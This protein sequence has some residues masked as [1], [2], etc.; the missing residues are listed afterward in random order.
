[1]AIKKVL[2]P[3]I[4][5]IVLAKRRGARYI[6]LS[7]TSRGIV[8][9]GM[10][11]WTPYSAGIS[12]AKARADWIAKHLSQHAASDFKDGDRFGKAHRLRISV[13][14]RIKAPRARIT[15][16]EIL[17]TTPYPVDD[18]RTQ[19]KIVSTADRTLR[20]EADTLLPQRLDELARKHGFH[21]KQV[22]IRS[23]TSRWGSCSSDRVITLSY[24]LIQLPWRLID[25]VILH[26]LVHTEQMN[27]GP[28][29]WSRM[30][31]FMPEAR[32][33]RRQVNAHKPRAIANLE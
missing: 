29:F 16:T 26:E 5:E 18:E 8:R 32:S 22:K 13:D 19:N 25:Y 9:V 31:K 27:H 20:K 3:E 17:V 30:E 4:G 15:S 2:I 23:L 6:R 14:K 11:Y 1:M 24:Y 33:I 12:F 7:V 21:Y 28:K 10:P